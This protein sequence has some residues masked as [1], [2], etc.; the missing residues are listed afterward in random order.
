MPFKI[1]DK[2]LI[3]VHQFDQYIFVRE[4]FSSPHFIMRSGIIPLHDHAIFA[5]FTCFFTNQL[6]NK[7]IPIVQIDVQGGKHF[8]LMD[9]ANLS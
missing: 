3:K 9:D 1:E 5:S 8:F 7:N 2:S 6:I 4:R